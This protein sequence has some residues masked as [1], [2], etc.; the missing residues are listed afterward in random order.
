MIVATVNERPILFFGDSSG[1]VY[2][3]D[4]ATGQPRWQLRADDHP[5]AMVTGTPAYY[6]GRLYVPVSSYE[7]VSAGTPGYVCCTFRGSLLALDAATGKQLWKTYTIA[8][9]PRPGKP[10]QK[11]G[12][13]IGPSGAGIWTAPTLDVLRGIVYVTTGDNYSDPPTLTSD[14]VIAL[15][16]DTGKLLWSKQMLAGDAFNNTCGSPSKIN[17][18]DSNGPDHDFGSSA[19]LTW[20]G[21]G[22]R[23]LILAQKSG[24][25]H[26]VDP[27]QNGRLLWQTRVG[28]GGVLGGIQWGPA[29]DGERVYVALSDLAFT[30]EAGRGATVDPNAGGGIFA[31]RLDNGERMWAAPP[32][33]CG[34]RRPCSPAQS[35]AVSGIAG[36]VFSGSM[37]GHLRAY[38]TADGKI[39]WDYD[40][41]QE[42]STVNGVTARGGAFDGGG[43]VMAGGM[44]FAGSGYGMWGAMPGNVLLAFSLEEK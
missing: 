8:E 12:K 11:G 32:P 20:M 33:G 39:L 22:K 27:D 4:A 5:A 37:D 43:A 42:F 9:T 15:S 25:L 21:N 10:T 36:A 30:R 44:L 29:S 14:A 19:I 34:E 2:A 28:K 7:E 38:S 31:F 13:T 1:Q 6:N 3:L 23:V 17:C 35:G 24:M 16:M 41:A 40:A 18:P 26:A